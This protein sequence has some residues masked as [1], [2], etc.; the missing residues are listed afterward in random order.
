MGW[1]MTVPYYLW[2]VL[3]FGFVDELAYAWDKLDDLA[4]RS[5]L[6]AWFVAYGVVH[7]LIWIPS[8]VLNLTSHEKKVKKE[9]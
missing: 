6:I 8:I 3:H 1:L 4:T 9:S 2:I 7:A 5:L